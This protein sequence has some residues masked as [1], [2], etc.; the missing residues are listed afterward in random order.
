LVFPIRA[1]FYYP[2]YTGNWFDKGSCNLSVPFSCATVHQPLA[3]FYN[4]NYGKVRWD[5]DNMQRAKVTTGITSWHGINHRT[6]TAVPDMLRAAADDGGNFQWA[7]YYELESGSNDPSVSTLQS[8]LSYIRTRYANHNNYLWKAGKPVIFVFTNGGDCEDLVRWRQATSNFTQ[9]YVSPQ[10][11]GGYRTCPNQPS[12][13]HQYAG[14]PNGD[15]QAGFSFTIAPEVWLWFESSA[16]LTRDLS[17]FKS[18]I[19]AQVA[20]RDPW[21]LIVSYNE[22]GESTVIEPG[23]HKSQGYWGNSYL[24]AL[25]TNGN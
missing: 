24:D 23:V 8:H 14:E 20:A 9:W 3:G 1:A 13:W 7:V 21:Q 4:Q 25:S 15:R 6:D 10:V 5:I 2:W 19:R 22:W 17:R 16:K 11:F 12:T 18:N